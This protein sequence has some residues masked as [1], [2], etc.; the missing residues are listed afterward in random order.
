MKTVKQDI[1]LSIIVPVYNVEEYLPVCIDSLLQQHDIR[2]EIILIDDGSTDRSGAIADRYAEKDNRIKVIHRKNGGASAA[3]NAGLEFAR[4]EYIAF[5][6]SDDWVKEDSLC[7]LYREAIKYRAEVVMAA[8][9]NQQSNQ[10]ISGCYKPVP[11]ELLYTPTCGKEGFMRMVKTWSYVSMI[12]NYLYRRDFLKKI[13]ARFE[14]GIMYEDELWSPGVLCQAER[15]VVTDIEF[16]YYRQNKESVMFTTN[17]FRRLDSMFRVTGKLM[18][19][20][21]RFEFSGKDGELKNWWY[22]NTFWLYSRAFAML[23]YVKNTSYSLP[24]HQLDRFWRDCWEMMPEPQR[25]CRNF[26][27]KAETDL[28]K[29]IEWCSSDWVASVGSQINVGKKLMLI[30]NVLPDEDLSLKIEDVPSDWVIT[31]D[32]RYFQR[33]DAVVFHLP[34]LYREEI[35]HDFDRQERQFWVSLCLESESEGSWM[36][37]PEIRDSF[38]LW[39]TCRQDADVELQ[40]EHPLVR[41]CRNVDEKRLSQKKTNYRK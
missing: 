34:T 20:A 13:Q 41:L 9:M 10:V 4:G 31:T 5:V 36:E 6:D 7:K 16:Y 18:E 32:R 3:R 11:K 38:D 19:F 2:L 24:K 21:D 39:M 17:L 1:D 14:E 40:K 25:I 12:W 23:R 22:V 8:L 35:E 28:K 26:F 29:Y 27:N 37:D 33:A 15:L 30:Y